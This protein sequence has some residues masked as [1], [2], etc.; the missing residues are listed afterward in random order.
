MEIYVLD[1]RK[2]NEDEIKL[3]E[4]IQVWLFE[5]RQWFYW[6]FLEQALMLT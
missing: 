5:I 3:N 1:K 6:G 4:V 2:K